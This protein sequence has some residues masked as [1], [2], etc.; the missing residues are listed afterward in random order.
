MLDNATPASIIITLVTGIP[1]L[2]LIPLSA[3]NIYQMKGWHIYYRIACFSLM[4]GLS[5]HTFCITLNDIFLLNGI[6]KR[7]S[8]DYYVLRSIYMINSFLSLRSPG[9]IR[10]GIWTF[11][12]ERLVATKFRKNYEKKKNWFIVGILLLAP[13]FYVSCLAIVN[14][15]F[16]AF[17][18]YYFN[19]CIVVDVLILVIGIYLYYVN[20]KLKINVSNNTNVL[21]SEKFQINENI[22]LI[23]LMLPLIVLFVGIN[24]VFNVFLVYIK[25]TFIHEDDVL[26]INELLL[27]IAYTGFLI[28]LHIVLKKIRKGKVTKMV[29]S[30]K[31]ESTV[32]LNTA[33]KNVRMVKSN[34]TA[35]NIKIYDSTGAN[36][37]TNYD[38]K[39]YFEM[40][41]RAW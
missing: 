24:L 25:L 10:I 23:K 31:K 9:L 15:F 37:P 26:A 36:I 30:K 16:P 21:L 13:F 22:R 41:A 29:E 7:I 19:F 33:E 4:I 38:Q 2:I 14:I 18:V 32:S 34:P 6:N 5:M 12:I 17:D 39:S 40:F 27:F 28:D 8:S 1:L 3:Y 35:G 11:V 20:R